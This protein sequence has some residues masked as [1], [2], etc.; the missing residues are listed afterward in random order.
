MLYIT[1]D[2]H[3][4]F[5]RVA[6]FCEAEKTTCDDTLVILG[7]AGIN[8][9]GPEKDLKLKEE[10]SKLP[11]TILC[12]H[13]NH[14]KRP[15]KIKGYRKQRF[16]EAVAYVEDRFPRLAFARDGDI[17]KIA[18]FSLTA[19]GGAYSMD[20][21]YRLAKNISWWA[22]E[23]PSDLIKRRVERSLAA[24]SWKV[25]LV[26]SHTC[27]ISKVPREV[28]PA[29]ISAASA[30]VSTEAWLERIENRLEYSRWYAGHF[31]V[32]KDD[33]DMRFVSNEFLA[34]GIKG[35]DS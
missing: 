1:G 29:G 28:F 32:D 17:Y 5:G 33:G 3:R 30:D 26:A 7:D 12:I 4:R 21:H 24:H 27:P 8:F 13:G 31:H 6:A 35:K 19:I 20:K 10:L 14:E 15:Q 9:F 22:D 11:I 2:T 18:G 34:V 23:Q 16:K 25:D